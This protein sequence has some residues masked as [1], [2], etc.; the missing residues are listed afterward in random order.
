MRTHPQAQ[1]HSLAGHEVKGWVDGK[2]ADEAEAVDGARGR[3]G[4]LQEAAPAAQYSQAT[5]I[6]NSTSQ[7]E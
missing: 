6:D 3:D 7:K 1:A 4:H 5:V 2:V